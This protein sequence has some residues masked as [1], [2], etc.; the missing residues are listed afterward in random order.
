MQYWWKTCLTILHFTQKTKKKVPL[1]R[2]TIL[3]C[4]HS[5]AVV[6]VEEEETEITN[7]VKANFV[8]V[9]GKSHAKIEGYA[10]PTPASRKQCTFVSLFHTFSAKIVGIENVRESQ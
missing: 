1:V 2:L 10:T 4:L 6:N 7:L 5:N 3:V 9:N 8:E